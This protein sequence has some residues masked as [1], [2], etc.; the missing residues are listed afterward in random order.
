MIVKKKYN[1]LKFPVNESKIIN[2]RLSRK[3]V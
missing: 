2:E 1:T 3:K